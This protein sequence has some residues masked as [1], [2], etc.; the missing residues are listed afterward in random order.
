MSSVPKV[1]IIDDEPV[2]HDVL[3]GMLA[4][5]DLEFLSA[6]DGETGLALA[7]KH[8]PDAILLD[9]MMPGMDGY[10]VCRQ[11]RA[12]PA[13]AEIPVIMITALND[14]DARLT[15]LTAGA[16]D[17]LTKP[18]DMV[19]IQ[20]RLRNIAR[21]N[22]FRS[23]LAERSRF[24]WV[25]E[26]DDKGYLVLAENG[27]IVYANQRAQVYFH[28]PETYH[29]L[30]FARQAERYYQPHIPEG[31]PA[32]QTRGKS[33][34]LVQPE[35]AGARA[36]WLRVE[37]LNTSL[38]G[39]N[40]RLVRVSD[41]TEEMSAYHDIRK[42]HVLVA[43]KLRTPV[44]HIC[45]SMTILGKAM[46]T[47]PEAEMRELVKDAWKG[48]ERLGRQVND[49]LEYLDAPVSL[50]EGVP[51]AVGALNPIV[52]AVGELL[53]L[54]DIA[55]FIP[56]PLAEH[57]LN[58]SI[59]ATELILH[60]ILEN[61]QKFHPHHTPHIQ[62]YAEA[63]GEDDIELRILDDGQT[64][65]AEQ[66]LRAKQPYAQGEKGFTGESPGMGLGIPLVSALVWQAGGDV[67]IENR[68]DGGGVCVRLILPRLR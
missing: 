2:I 37:V 67:R 20:V 35:S 29:D 53:G 50:A 24:L 61:S 48:A 14:R 13:L 5:E 63:F 64:M 25:V 16:D 68:N 45:M 26:N 56:E 30:N 34:Y 57:R 1:L 3:E 17:F 12:T 58:I 62:V 42:I 38:G 36:F 51:V 31:G 11:I 6:E 65:T 28:L 47:L 46:D 49:I 23:L 44:A 10:E 52:T 41:V 40:Q 8:L 21:I 60:E 9:I 54:K 66:I 15:G 33:S 18:F 39:E 4:V 19:E 59:N 55:V 43:H 22:R 27:T 7:R 32:Y